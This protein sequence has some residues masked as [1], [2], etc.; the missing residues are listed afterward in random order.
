MFRFKPLIWTAFISLFSCMIA[1]P[2]TAEPYGTPLPEKNTSGEEVQYRKKEVQDSSKS[3]NEQSIPDLKMAEEVNQRVLHPKYDVPRAMWI[4]NNDFAFNPKK[5]TELLTFC[6]NRQIQ[7][8]YLY[9]GT[10]TLFNSRAGTDKIENFLE[11]A[12]KAE[13][14][15]HALDGW[16]TALLPDRQAEFLASLQRILDFNRNRPAERRFDGF[17]SDV[18][19]DGLPGYHQSDEFRR[20][21][22]TL[23]I[24]L[25]DRC[26]RLITESGMKNF[27]FG[28]AIA[29]SYDND[30]PE[31]YTVFDDRSG[32]VAQ[33]MIR[34]VDYFAIMSYHDLADRIIHF[35]RYEV[36]LAGSYGKKAWVGAETINARK[37]NLPS[38]ITFYEE[39]LNEMEKELEAVTKAF[40]GNKGFGGVAIHYYGAYRTLPD[41]PRIKAVPGP[42][43]KAQ[44]AESFQRLP[45]G[46]DQIIHSADNLVHGHDNWNGPDDLS[47]QIRFGWNPRELL[48]RVK[49]KD[50]RFMPGKPGTEL[51]KGDHVEFW[52]NVNKNKT[53]YQIGISPSGVENAP[54]N[55]YIWYP[56]DFSPE[57]RKELAALVKSRSIRLEDGYSMEC[58]IPAEVLGLEKFSKDLYIKMLFEAGDMDSSENPC[59]TMLSIAPERS[60]GKA[61]TYS[62]LKLED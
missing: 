1:T 34:I 6:R 26:R 55:V 9:T 47:C 62:E 54:D 49:V 58:I 13:I 41:L 37:H 16:P 61:F 27:E 40:Y 23:F 7:I 59:K 29:D 50:D 8:L 18:E 39:G 30:G 44:Y 42:V 14:R 20:K 28:L 15:V 22:D 25:H 60:R 19:P 4:W 2:V 36:N 38:S 24:K 46:Y 43:F 33:Q 48:V 31:K 5:N 21:V 52:F 56:V 45:P 17:Q 10:K 35:S 3:L 12:H 51:W 32:N 57:K 53:D 11:R